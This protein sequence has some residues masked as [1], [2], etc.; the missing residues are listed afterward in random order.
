MSAVTG[1]LGIGG[2]QGGTSF[3]TQN[4]TNPDQIATS[5]NQ[6]QQLLQALQGQNGLGDQSQVYNQLQGV[7]NGTGPNPAQA[8]LNQSTGANVANQAALMAGQRGAGANV[9]L[10]ARQAANTGANIQAQ[11]AGQGATMQANQS[12]NALQGA[13]SLATNMAGNQISATQNEQ[14]TLQ[15]ANTANNSNQTTMAGNQQKTQAAGIGGLA[16]GVAS[17]LPFLADGG[18]VPQAGGPQSMFAK[19]L[20]A[21]A[22]TPSQSQAQ[23]PLY[24]GMHDLGSAIGGLFKPSAQPSM[25][26]A[27]P[28]A[29]PSPTMVAAKGGKVPAMV[30]PGEVYLKPQAAKAVA[31]GKANPMSA[32]EKIPG[33]PKVK[34]NSYANDVVPKKLDVGG[35]VI[36]NSV[37]QSKDPVRGAADFVRDVMAKKRKKS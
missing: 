27:G 9:G 16:S 25:A 30:S 2:G 36:P 18:A 33:T 37:M 11:A 1:M 3:S 15:A 23:D 12:L 29:A 7:A 6:N 26:Y 28:D 10:M 32:G 17:A 24:S 20:K 31:Q 35:V 4:G 21:I 19:S 8:M 13:G 14:N 5:Y 22:G 34:G